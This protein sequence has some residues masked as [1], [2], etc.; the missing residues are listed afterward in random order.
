MRRTVLA[1]ILLGLSVLPAAAQAPDAATLQAAK[2]VVA[3]MQGDRTAAL[4][5]M[6]G[7]MVGMIQQM[8]V[9]ETDRAQV[10]VQE[11]IIPVMTAHYDE[12]LDIQARSYAGAL[13]RPDLDAV[14]AFY[15]TP[16]GR[17]FAAAQP[18]LAQAQL[19]GMTQWMGTIA[20][21]MQT[22]L[23]QAMQARG[24]SPKR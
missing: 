22:K 15:D 18:K 11:V 10:L 14:A 23:S 16:A 21:E 9:R 7:P 2:T 6:S 8:G 19:T 17:N 13:S 24:W 4:A 20:P 3:K 1:S 12:L 5:A